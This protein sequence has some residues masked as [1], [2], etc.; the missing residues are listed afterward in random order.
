MRAL[1]MVVGLV[2]GCATSPPNYYAECTERGFKPDSPDH[3]GCM[4]DMYEAHTGE[5]VGLLGN[6]YL[7]PYQQDAYGPGVHS[8]GAGKAFQ[9]RTQDGE[10]VQGDVEPNAYGPGVGMDE[11]GRPVYP[12]P[13]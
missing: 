12:A 3:S 10:R 1:L 7:G 4:L 8:D 2:A 6:G 9:W 13:Y 11:Y 5:S